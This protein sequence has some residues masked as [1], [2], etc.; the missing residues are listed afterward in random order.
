MHFLVAFALNIHLLLKFLLEPKIELTSASAAVCL[1]SPSLGPPWLGVNAVRARERGE[2]A[3]H[4]NFAA[5]AVVC[6][7]PA[8][9]RIKRMLKCVA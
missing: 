7:L 8:N 6:R 2:E 9:E 3:F 4:S 1:V 5:D